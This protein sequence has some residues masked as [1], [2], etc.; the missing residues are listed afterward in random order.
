MLATRWTDFMA[1]RRKLDPYTSLFVDRHGKER[2]RFRR[3][4]RSVYLPHPSAK[5]YR[6]AYERALQGLAPTAGPR[7]VP[8]TIGDLV[9]RFYESIAFKKGG[10]DWQ[11]T[12]RQVLEP[13]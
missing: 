10:K 4:G 2:C 7:A 8:R 6:E 1:R 13:F 11:K 3:H 9:P 5:G 12:V